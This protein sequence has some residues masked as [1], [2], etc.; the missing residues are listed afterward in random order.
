MFLLCS[1]FSAVL[2][3][4]FFF[5][6][7]TDVAP[8]TTATA[9]VAESHQFDAMIKEKDMTNLKPSRPET[10]GWPQI[11]ISLVNQFGKSV[12]SEDNPSKR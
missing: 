8:S 3:I 2:L 6:S 9:A 7:S 12:S 4:I 1:L 11:P 5:V 10:D